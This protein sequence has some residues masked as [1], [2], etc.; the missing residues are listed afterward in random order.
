MLDRKA[1]FGYTKTMVANMMQ[2]ETKKVAREYLKAVMARV[3]PN[4][5]G[6]WRNV[7][8]GTTNA[9]LTETSKMPGPSWSL[10][11][12][13][14]C[15]RACGDI[16]NEGNCYATKGM[17]AFANVK[18]AQEARFGWTRE[19]LKTAEGRALW[20]EV[21]VNAIQ[22]VNVEYFRVHDAGDMFN[23][24]YAEMWFQVISRLPEVK[25]WI[26]TRAWQLPG[27]MLPVFD[28]LMNTLRKIASLPNAS[29]RPSALNF[30][31]AAPV[32]SGLHAGASAGNDAAPYQCPAYKQDGN[33]GDCRHCWTDKTQ[34]VNYPIH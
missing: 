2:A 17:Y 23:V 6:S 32:V 21:M 8:P 22:S 33:C 3:K 13:R 19:C 14:S 28:P 16:C 20:V 12:G 34:S 24:A 4:P 31:E 7:V 29:V 27:G 1:A 5:K 25:F 11:A 10:P 26:P 18:A 15:P 30:G 9:L